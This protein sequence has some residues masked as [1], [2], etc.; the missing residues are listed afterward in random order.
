[1]L[2]FTCKEL[3]DKENHKFQYKEVEHGGRAQKYF[4]SIE[5]LLRADMEK[6]REFHIKAKVSQNLGQW[7]AEELNG[8][9]GT[10]SGSLAPTAVNQQKFYFELKNGIV[11]AKNLGGF[12]SRIDLFKTNMLAKVLCCP[13]TR[14]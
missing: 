9:K 7:H 13:Y 4:S 10:G 2:S 12:Y 6:H 14:Q 8:L 1:M 3:L 5:W 11:T